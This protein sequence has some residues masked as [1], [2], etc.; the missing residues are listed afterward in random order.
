MLMGLLLVTMDG[1]FEM[2]FVFDRVRLA[3]SRVYSGVVIASANQSVL[4][5]WDVSRGCKKREWIP[6]QELLLIYS[7]QGGRQ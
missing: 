7:T 4:V 5:E 3:R 6:R 2:I 1:S